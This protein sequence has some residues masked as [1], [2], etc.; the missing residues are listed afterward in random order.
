[1]K[2]RNSKRSRAAIKAVAKAMKPSGTVSDLK[3]WN[4]RNVTAAE[5]AANVRFPPFSSKYAW[6]SIGH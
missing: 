1:M 6:C 2:H 5:S 4:G 3:T